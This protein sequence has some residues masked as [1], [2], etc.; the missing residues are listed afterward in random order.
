MTKHNL[1]RFLCIAGCAAMASLSIASGADAQRK[2]GGMRGGGMRPGA[3]GA[4]T[5]MDFSASNRAGRGM[6][7]Q[8]LRVRRDANTNVNYN[9]DVNR[10]VNRELNVDVDVHHSYGY[11]YNWR[12]D[13]HP[14]A[15]AA[16][17]TAAIA[18]TAAIIGSYYRALPTNCVVVYRVGLTYYQCGSAWYQPTYVGSDIQYVVVNAP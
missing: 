3:G 5:R 11:G 2:G 8:D 1:A 14:I 16:V 4:G 13:Y 18:T 15:R 6:A 9:R 17:A 12:N 7:N 10:N